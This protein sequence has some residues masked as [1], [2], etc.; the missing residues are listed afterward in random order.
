MDIEGLGYKTAEEFI[1]NGFVKNVAD[2]YLLRKKKDEILSLEGWGEKSFQKLVDSIEGSKSR[3]LYRII[4]ALGIFGVGENTAHLL[5]DHFGSIERL[6]HAGEEGINKIHGIGPVVAHSVHQFFNDKIN[7]DIIKLLQKYGV[8]FPEGVLKIKKGPLLNKVF[9]LTGTLEAFTRPEAQKIIEEFGGKV[10]S[11]VS[12]NTDYVV[13]GADP[14]SK[15]DKAST[16][17]IKTLDEAEFKK[18]IGA[19]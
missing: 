12:K 13:V 2:I 19:K 7:I 16:L 1:D 15:A 8:I 14:G 10:T 6:M 9:V 5:A 3:E 4:Y 17:G 11:S 18:L